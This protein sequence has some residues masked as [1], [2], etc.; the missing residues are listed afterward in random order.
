[1][2]LG[3]V[4]LW[5]AVVKS[6]SAEF[7]QQ[8]Q[9][10]MVLCFVVSCNIMYCVVLCNVVC[11]SMVSN[12]CQYNCIAYIAV[13]LIVSQLASATIVK[14]LVKYF[15]NSIVCICIKVITIEKCSCGSNG[16]APKLIHQSYYL[17][18]SFSVLF[19]T[20]FIGEGTF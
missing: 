11:C 2:I 15:I 20:I 8:F 17:Q 9:Q 6:G 14:S 10:Y 5:E 16:H 1:M 18:N 19:L 13:Y 3:E 4:C 12:F 7:F